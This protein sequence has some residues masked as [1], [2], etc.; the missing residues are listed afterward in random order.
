MY[1]SIFYPDNTNIYDFR[2][3]WRNENEESVYDL[4]YYAGHP[5]VDDEAVGHALLIVGYHDDE[6]TDNSDYWIILN[7]WGT[8]YISP[9][10]SITR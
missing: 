9:Q 4:D 8:T 3:F 5:W 2:Y 1:F 10:W 7:S 6:N